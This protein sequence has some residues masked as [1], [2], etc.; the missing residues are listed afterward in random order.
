[1][2]EARRVNWVL[3]RSRYT[4]KNENNQTTLPFIKLP[5]LGLKFFIIDFWEYHGSKLCSKTF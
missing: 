3:V 5:F 1:M 2:A 4:R